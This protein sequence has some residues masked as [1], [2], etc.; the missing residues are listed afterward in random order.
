MVS[1]AVLAWWPCAEDKLWFRKEQHECF[2]RMSLF[3]GCGALVFAHIHHPKLWHGTLFS[4]IVYG[5][6]WLWYLLLLMFYGCDSERARVSKHSDGSWAVQE[7]VQPR[8]V[9]NEDGD[10]DLTSVCAV[11]IK[12]RSSD[13]SLCYDPFFQPRVDS[14][15]PLQFISLKVPMVSP[16]EWH[17]FYMSSRPVYNE[18]DPADGGHATV[19]FTIHV[20]SNARSKSQ[21]CS[22]FSELVRSRA[23]NIG[24]IRVMGPYGRP[25]IDVRRYEHLVLVGQDIGGVPLMSVLDWLLDR[26]WGDPDAGPSRC[27]VVTL[28]WSAQRREMFDSFA[29]AGPV[30]G[31]LRLALDLDSAVPPGAAQPPREERTNANFTLRAQ[32]YELR[33]G[34]GGDK[35][36]PTGIDHSVEGIDD[37]DLQARNK[38][39]VKIVYPFSP[40][41][42][43]S[44]GEDGIQRGPEHIVFDWIHLQNEQGNPDPSLAGLNNQ[45][46]SAVGVVCCGPRSMT[47]EVEMSV[48]KFN[49]QGGM[50]F[51]LH[52]EV[53]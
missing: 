15:G 1:I 53:W 49:E 13:H 29:R 47:K 44:S 28:V 50:Q 43:R 23:G 31:V 40:T 38:L 17:P 21:W 5:I 10:H 8:A 27:R 2:V 35:N 42:W 51:H 18:S 7:V 25:R 11:E 20:R 45:R 26:R 30:P 48:D 39:G 46:I 9:Y 36:A 32:L 41:L 4:M 3:F 34:P 24:P 19:T 33:E 12:V 37:L 52:N 22:L 14:T 6:D 16:W